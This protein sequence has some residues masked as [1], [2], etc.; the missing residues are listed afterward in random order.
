M[1]LNKI[2]EAEFTGKDIEGLVDRPSEAGLSATLLKERFDSI[3]KDLITPKF[4]ALIDALQAQSGSSEIGFTPTAKVAFTN[5]YL[6]VLGS[7]DY[8]DDQITQAL[9]PGFLPEAVNIS[10][11][12]AGSKFTGTNVETVLLELFNKIGID[13][14]ALETA[15]NAGGLSTF[16]KTLITASKVLV[17]DGSGKIAASSLDSSKLAFLANVTSD[18]QAQID[19]ID[20]TLTADLITDANAATATGF[21]RAESTAT[22]IPAARPCFIVTI[23]KDVNNLSQMYIE[24]AS[25]TVFT[26]YFRVRS[27]STWGAWTKVK[28]GV[29][30]I[31]TSDP[32]GGNDGDIWYKV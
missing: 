13:I 19:N 24:H 15:Y 30:T 18:I 6:A 29:E 26:Q 16:L 2:L 28:T 1:A 7:F 10:V 9:L 3:S 23:A 8:T 12:D 32:S 22:N 5:L 20:V 25:S 4:N 11:A 31:S 21:Y 27:G 14:A 17:S